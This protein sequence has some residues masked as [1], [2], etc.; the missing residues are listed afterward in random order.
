MDTYNVTLN[1]LAYGI[2]EVVRGKISDDDDIAL[3]H[4]KDMIHSTRAKLLKQKFDKNS[5]VI[6]DVFTQSLGDSKA[7][8]I[9]PVDSSIHPTITAG[10][11]VYRTKLELPETID[12]KNYEGTFTRIGPA[13]TLA[14]K[15]HLVSYDRALHSGHGRFNKDQIYCFLRD[16]KM[17]LISYSGA[18]HKGVQ[19]IDIVGV[20]QNPKQVAIF[21][22]VSGS[23]L[24]FDDESYPISRAMKDDIEKI[25]IREKLGVQA[26]AP[27]DLINDGTH[28]LNAK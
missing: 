20:F 9:E 7:L 13:D 6:D 19:Y 25:I 10:R 23:S 2:F 22:D 15:Y 18:Y 3:N 16:R 5:R 26:N 24:T 27:S 8:E 14:S 11:Y 28:E 17:H 1:Q 12:R 21:K 4:I